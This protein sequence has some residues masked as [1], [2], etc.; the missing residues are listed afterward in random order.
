MK[1]SRKN[2]TEEIERMK[3]LFT[4]ERLYGNLV[5]QTAG[6]GQTTKD[7]RKNVKDTNKDRKSSQ[8]TARKNKR[9]EESKKREE[10]ATKKKAE[11]QNLT[12]CRKGINNLIKNFLPKNIKKRSTVEQYT[13]NLGGEEAYDNVKNQFNACIKNDKVKNSITYKFNGQPAVDV[14][15]DIINNGNETYL[16]VNLG[17][18]PDNV[19]N[20]GKKAVN[21][22]KNLVKGDSEGGIE[23]KEGGKKIGTISTTTIPNQYTLNGDKKQYFLNSQLNQVRNQQLPNIL[24]AL[25]KPNGKIT[26]VANTGKRE[27]Y[28]DSFEFTVS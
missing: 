11:V 7:Q 5:E 27:K 8:S 28:R 9:G 16:T 12:N 1:T 14:L 21:K 6:F 24:T 15:N 23:V 13:K 25:K 22:I 2:I 3:S 17:V 19:L 4:E 18:I 10:E 26:V 20:K